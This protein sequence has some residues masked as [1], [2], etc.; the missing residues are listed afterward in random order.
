MEYKVK[1]DAFEGPLDLLLH[2]I[3]QLEIDLYDIPVA[4]ITEQYLDFIHKMQVLELDV[5]SEYLVMAATLI[6]MKS[7]MLLPKQE[8]LEE[9]LF[10]QN[11]A[12]EEDPRDELMRRL[13]DYRQYKQAAQELKELEQEQIRLYT[14]SPSDLSCYERTEQALPAEGE[15][16]VSDMISALQRLLKKKKIN[17]P[18]NTKIERQSLPIGKRMIEIV[19]VLKAKRDLVSFDT[20]FPYPDRSHVVV[21]FLALLELMKKKQITCNQETNFTDISICL[22][23]GAEPIE[24]DGNESSY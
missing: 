23:K 4:E 19:D 24:I 6:E 17:K 13:I 1:I 16:T 8:P 20:L 18:M 3:K 9:D 22:T 21:T 11:M 5:A 14:K 15:V 12:L 10:D 7:K 2:L